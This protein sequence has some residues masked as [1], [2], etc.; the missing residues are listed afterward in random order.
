[1]RFL[2][3][4]SNHTLSHLAKCLALRERLLAA[5]HE[6]HLAASAARSAFLRRLRVPH[7]LLPDLCEAD[8]GSSPSFAW[9]RPARFEASVR[10]ELELI[11]R[12]H[13]DRVLGVFR[14]TAAVSARLA[15]VPCD[16]LVCGCVTPACG[17]VLGFSPGEP[18]EQAQA[19]ALAFFRRASASRIGP[20]LHRLGAAP[21]GDAWE[22]VLGERTFLWDTPE[23]QP[24]RP[25][26]GLV[27]VG[28]VSFAGWPVD[29]FALERLAA[30]PPPLA[31]V[32]F[33]TGD[34]HAAVAARLTAV[35][36]SMGFSVARAS[37]GAGK[38]PDEGPR[39]A[40]FE[41]LP[42]P[43]ALARAAL[44]ACHGGQGIAFEA[45]GQRVPVAV[46]PF[47]P[48]QAQNGRCL[49]RLGCGL[50]LEH[51]PV[52]LPGEPSAEE[53][54]LSRPVAGV[55]KRID[56][57]LSAREG[58]SRRRAAAE[59]VGRSGGIAALASALERRP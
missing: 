34:S 49:E 26:A 25:L 27:H 10:A 55:A 3:L 41:F 18:G 8:G 7:H 9:F 19:D 51:G 4:P 16:S 1:M 59:M 58:P 50:R 45:L 12:L 56:A 13:P 42:M 46:V 48:E 14:F 37:G 20:A 17:E 28:P 39:V 5:G 24:L 31:V 33:G 53:S 57:L 35:L 21:V 22:L 32:C 36:L 38:V 54:F 40:S 43:E 2:L 23:F 52:A 44:V 30:L 11:H 15:G 6:V 47:Q 29:P